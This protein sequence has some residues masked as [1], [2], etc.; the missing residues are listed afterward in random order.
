M[1]DRIKQHGLQAAVDV[2]PGYVPLDQMPGELEPAHIGL[3]PYR[4]DP[5]MADSL[6]SKLLEY[7][8]MGLPVVASR[9][10]Y[11]HEL[12][13]DSLW[14]SEPGDVSSLAAAMLRAADQPTEARRR[15]EVAKDVVAQLSW[16]TQRNTYFGVVDSLLATRGTTGRTASR[17]RR[18]RGS[19]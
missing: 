18:S 7:A 3:A 16:D 9:L 15:V 11:I 2:S 5:F 6:P 1:I 4:L 8:A 19:A 10:P 13:G 17:S 14:Y 12:F